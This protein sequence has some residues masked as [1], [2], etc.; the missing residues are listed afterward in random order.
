[1]HAALDEA[2]L[3][4]GRK[5]NV[6]GVAEEDGLS[7]ATSQQD[8]VEEEFADAREDSDQMASHGTFCIDKHLN[9]LQ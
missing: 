8:G 7:S 4:Q 6:S 3:A 9:I 2:G 1:M 5:P